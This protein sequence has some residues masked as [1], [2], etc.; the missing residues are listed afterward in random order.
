MISIL[1]L[2]IPFL[3]VLWYY[4]PA[5]SLLTFRPFLQGA[6]GIFIG[7]MLSVACFKGLMYENSK[8]WKSFLLPFVSALII[9]WVY[10]CIHRGLMGVILLPFG[11]L[12][13]D[14]SIC[15][16]ILVS[17][18]HLDGISYKILNTKILISIGII[19][20]SLYIW[21]NLLIL[22]RDYKVEVLPRLPVPFNFL[23]TFIVSYF[24]YYYFEKHFLKLKK[25]LNK[26]RVNK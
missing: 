9:F 6:D 5:T 4:Y 23:L 24:S 13:S 16:L 11:S 18:L 10:Y 26:A 2:F 15:I 17:I 12:I 25:N 3:H 14:L 1:F 22:P 20:Y 21:H 7:S 19:S 8:L